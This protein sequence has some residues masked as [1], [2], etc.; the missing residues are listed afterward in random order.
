MEDGNDKANLP[1]WQKSVLLG[2]IG[3]WINGQVAG[4]KEFWAA[5]IICRHCPRPRQAGFRA[6]LRWP[7]YENVECLGCED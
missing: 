3:D 5:S 6:G 4:Y 1:D 2:Q 7:R